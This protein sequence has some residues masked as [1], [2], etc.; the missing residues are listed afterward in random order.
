MLGHI[1]HGFASALVNYTRTYWDFY[2]DVFTTFTGAITAL[3]IL[4]TFSAERFF[5]AIVD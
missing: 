4:T 5:K 1:T 2:G 3:A